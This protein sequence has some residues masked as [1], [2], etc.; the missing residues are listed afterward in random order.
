MNHTLSIRGQK[1]VD[2]VLRSDFEIFFEASKDLFHP[3]ENPD[4]KITLN[5]AEN[6]LSWPSLKD[7]IEI[8]TLTQSIPDW[9]AGY[10][11]CLGNPDFLES[12]AGFLSRYLF[13]CEI[14]SETLGIS[15][16][17]TAIVE[18]TSWIL[19]DRGDIAMIPAPSYPVYTMDI[20]NKGG[21]ERYDIISHN[22]I[23]DLNQGHPLS[24]KHLSKAYNEI[25]SAGKRPRMLILTAPDNPTGTVYSISKLKEIT[26]WCIGNEVHL[27][28]NEIY[29]LSLIL[30]NEEQLPEFISFATIMEEMKSPYLHLWYSLSKDLGISGFRVGVVHSYNNSLLKAYDNLNAPHM[31]SNHTQWMLGQI[32]SDDEFLPSYI[33]ENQKRLTHSFR[34]VTD[35]LDALSIPYVNATG[36]L[37][38]WL[39]MS[40]F[41]Q[42]Q[43]PEGDHHLWMDIYNKTG[44]LLTPGDGFGHE[45]YGLFRLVYSCVPSDHLKEAMDRIET[46]IQSFR[47]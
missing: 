29:G 37:F 41:I 17:A 1:A 47:T 13:K 28:V 44:V 15:A 18:V 19:C 22:D 14:P 16:G 10:T 25:I 27:V 36:S 30:D 6:V 34:I 23:S 20:G 24:I 7:K 31:V 43:T 9:V 33:H 39:D 21:V 38:V 8:I 3:T 46:Y 32:L 26:A 11:S 12:L 42:E 45:G 2:Q 4:G 40:E 35:K 5:V